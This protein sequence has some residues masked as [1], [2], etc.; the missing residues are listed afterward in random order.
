MPS[1]LSYSAVT[2]GVVAASALAAPVANDVGSLNRR[3]AGPLNIIVQNRHNNPVNLLFRAGAL[4]GSFTAPN[5]AYGVPDVPVNNIAPGTDY[6]ATIDE[7]TNG[8]IFVGD[9]A[10][11]NGANADTDSTQIEFTWKTPNLDYDVSNVQGFS[12]PVVCYPN[13]PTDQNVA[14]CNIDLWNLPGQPACPQDKG[15]GVCHNTFSSEQTKQAGQRAFVGGNLPADASD[16]QVSAVWYRWQAPWFAPCEGGSYIGQYDDAAA[17]LNAD[18]PG[19]L[20]CC[21]GASC[22]GGSHQAGPGWRDGLAALPPN[23]PL[24]WPGPA[25]T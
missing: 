10:T 11:L 19:Q 9:A 20:T 17:N 22:V 18:N 12:L 8:S 13:G 5:A 14:G 25:W 3:Q 1:T 23:P 21:V 7:G 16:A 15:N 6:T 24:T 4:G 2:L